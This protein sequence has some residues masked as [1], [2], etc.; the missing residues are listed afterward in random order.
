MPALSLSTA[1][2]HVRVDG[3]D[4]DTLIAALMSRMA[5]TKSR[6][7]AVACGLIAVDLMVI[8]GSWPT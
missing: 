2:I 3:S 1:K 4:D 5:M 7:Q 8:T 6:S